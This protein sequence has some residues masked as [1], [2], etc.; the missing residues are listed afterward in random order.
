M[1]PGRY[2]GGAFIA[3]HGSWNRAPFPQQGYNVVFVPF[4]GG[5]PTGTFEVFADGFAG[6]FVNPGQA[7]HRPAGLAVGPDGALYIAD[8]AHGRIW[9]VAYTGRTTT[10]Q[11][12]AR[13]VAQPV[14]ATAGTAA[15]PEGIHPNAGVVNTSASAA[16]RAAGITPAMV[17]LGDSVYHGLVAS[18]T[19]AGCHGTNAKG[20]SLAPNLTSN[21]WL[22]GDGSYPSILATITKGVANPMQHPGV[23]PPMGGAQLTQAQLA[24]VA[25]YVWS[26]SHP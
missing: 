19:C 5:N 7:A 20:S 13:Q 18:G 22:W 10:A 26:L 21:K 1:F 14:P 15:P 25:A 11:S 8:D 24:A 3:F 2:R 9:R 4:A 23:M 16:A 6:A 12:A 17:A